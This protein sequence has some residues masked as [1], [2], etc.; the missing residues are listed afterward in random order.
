MIQC[1]K[2]GAEE[3]HPDYYMLL[4]RANKVYDDEGCWSQ[5]L[6][7]AGYYERKDPKDPGYPIDKMARLKGGWFTS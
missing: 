2:C 6:I 5:C 1:P 7:C 3:M 4:I